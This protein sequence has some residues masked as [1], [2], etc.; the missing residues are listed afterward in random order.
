MLSNPIDFNLPLMLR[1]SVTDGTFICLSLTHA[2][3]PNHGCW[4]I[5]LKCKWAVSEWQNLFSNR[6]IYI[7]SVNEAVKHP[8]I[9]QLIIHRNNPCSCRTSCKSTGDSTLM[10]E[11]SPK[12]YTMFRF[13]LLLFS[14][15]Q[16]PWLSDLEWDEEK[17][18][19]WNTEVR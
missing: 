14:L 2:G 8:P 15:C 19:A 18:S 12:K 11:R 3:T 17:K 13:F 6:M 7:Q 4:W 9:N 5:V 16:F 10:G 1:I